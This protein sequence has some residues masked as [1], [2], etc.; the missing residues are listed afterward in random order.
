VFAFFTVR[1][2]LI[3]G[4][5][6]L[7][8]AIKLDR[9]S[10]V[11]RVARLIGV[12]AITV[13][14]IIYHVALRGLLDLDTWGLAADT[15]VHTVVPIVAVIGWLRFGPRGWTSKTVVRATMVFPAFYM[16]FTMIRGEIVGFYPYPFADV[17]TL[18]YV[19]VIINGVWVTLIFFG[20]ASGAHALDQLLVS[21]SVAPAAGRR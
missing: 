1:S 4:A 15:I 7:L 13:T 12:V 19:R 10:I 2:N 8:L 18:G 11:F 21:R 14:G 3:V 17:G 16:L 6:C 5:T 20:L 9:R